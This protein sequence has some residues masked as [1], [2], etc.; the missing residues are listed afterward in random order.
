MPRLLRAHWIGMWL[1]GILATGLIVALF[2]GVVRQP[3]AYLYGSQ[4]DAIKNYYTLAYYV[5]YDTGTRFTGMNYPYGEH[6]N[7]P[8][9]QPLLAM[10]LAWARA[11]GLA[12]AGHAGVAFTN[13]GLLLGLVLAAL[14]LYAILRRLLLPVWYA[15]LAALLITFL[16]PQLLRFQGHM[17]LGY[18]C[19]VPVQWY[20]LL[21]AIE[22][23]RR[24]GWYVVLGTFNLLVGLLA[25][26]HLG[27]G[28]LLVFAH[29]PVLAWQQG[30]RRS[31]ALLWRLAA[32]AIVPL[33]VF[34][35][36]L[37]LTDPVADRPV[38]PYGLLNNYASFSSLFTPS[39]EPL[40]APW[41]YIFHTDTP[42]FEGMVYVGL[43]G[44]LVLLCT[45]WLAGR[46][47]RRGQWRR[48]GQPV[49]PAGLRTTLWAAVLLLP[50]AT[51]Q[52]FRQPG[53]EWLTV[54]LGPFKQFRATG[55]FAWAFYYVFGAYAAFY[56][57]QLWRYLRQ[58]RAP[59]FATMWL[60]PL[61][62][63][64]GG[65][66]AWRVRPVAAAIEQRR[67]A[68][69]FENEDHNYQALL[70]WTEWP[71]QR[72]QAILPLPFFAVGT[73]KIALDGTSESVYQAYRAALNLH[74]PL[75]AMSLGRAS[76]G[77]TLGVTQ[78]LSNELI[79]K[80]LLAHFPSQKP[81]L[82]LVTPQS[83]TSAE[84]RLVSLAHKITSTPEVTLY[85]L[86]ISALAAT[87]TAA[88]RTKAA[89]LLPTLV[90]HE[91]LY[92]TTGK[93]AI[94][95]GFDQQPDRRGRLG[96]GAWYEPLDKF[97][98][99]YDGPLPTPA[100]TGRYEAS[101]WVN[102]RTGYGLGGMQVKVYGQGAMLE[103][104]AADARH[105]TDVDGDWVRVVV[106]FRRPPGADRIEV[107]YENR[108]LLADDLLIRPLDTDVYWR[109]AKGQPVLNGYSLAP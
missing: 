89:A 9:L 80:P 13:V 31:R 85:E 57:Y 6:V 44:L 28:S 41:Q 10:P 82:L 68:A 59:A 49:L 69:A 71:A 95:R 76:I 93:G 38:N 96:A 63:L 108:D 23:P 73:D 12:S 107:L 17:S 29:V 25:A 1:V 19:F 24:P 61:L 86:P 53:L 67:V 55:R 11:A 48:I 2:P 26:Y 77:Q 88:E 102:A 79:A 21:R 5:K 83:L 45:L 87:T 7:Y 56:I 65:E 99:L 18:A 20:L 43:V 22:A 40:Q 37:A 32:T 101:V 90:P 66:A 84:Q 50:F 64:W 106:P 78:L 109:D 8:D 15:G 3:G 97:S 4:G 51:M 39:E 35:L 94:Y 60:L 100:D 34:R 70:G 27:I 62:A 52:P 54:L 91:G 14:A 33:L 98:T 36:W 81:I 74:L 92:T 16:S 72:F 30:W 46:Y 75:L 47:L 103:L 104:Q 105:V 58:H 42:L